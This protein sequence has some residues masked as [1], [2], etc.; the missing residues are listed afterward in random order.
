VNFLRFQAAIHI[1][2]VN[3]AANVQIDQDN[4]RMKCLALNVDFNGV[5]FDP[6]RSMSPLY[7]RIK[8]GY[9]LE[10]VRF[11][12]LLTNLARQWLQIDTDLLRIITST[13][14]KLPGGTNI[15]D[16]ERP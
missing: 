12:L 16:L 5:R 14:V 7:K 15:D 3:C 8:F 9:P 2:R 13:A 10:N 4:L 6:L 11:L 1:L